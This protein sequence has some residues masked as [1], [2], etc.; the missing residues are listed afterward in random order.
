[1]IIREVAV[2]YSSA[3]NDYFEAQSSD[4]KG[5]GNF[6]VGSDADD[7]VVNYAN[8]TK[9]HTADGNDTV[10]T[11]A[12]GVVIDTADGDD[13]II[14]IGYGTDILAGSGNDKIHTQG[15][16]VNIDK[17]TGSDTVYVTGKFNV[18]FANNADD[19]ADTYKTPPY[20]FQY[21]KNQ[22]LL[23]DPLYYDYDTETE[24]STEETENIE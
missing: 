24:E 2:A 20:I 5:N 15:S 16:D 23:L 4:R 10:T 3:I 1:M 17:G 18:N 13:A 19:V 7:V 22:G 21:I 6:F 8:G 14:A 12:G 9:I 11:I